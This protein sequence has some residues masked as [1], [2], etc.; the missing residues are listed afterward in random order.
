MNGGE[1]SF[2]ELDQIHNKMET[3]LGFDGAYVDDIFY[4]P[5][6]PHRGYDG[7]I[8]ELKIECECRK[9]KPG[10]ILMAAEKY[11]IDLSNSWMIGNHIRDIEAGRKASCKTAFIGEK[12]MDVESYESLLHFCIEKF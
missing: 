11:N 7:E 5:H 10:L 2:D 8:L 3:L 4:C 9:P 12:Q 1:L 6:H